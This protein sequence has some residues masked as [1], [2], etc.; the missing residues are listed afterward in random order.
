MRDTAGFIARI[1]AGEPAADFREDVPPAT[2]TAE[3]IAFGLR[4]DRG[5]AESLL[6]PWAETVAGH[7]GEGLMARTAGGR[8][9]LTPRGRMVADAV[10]EG[11]V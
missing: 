4:T 7:V 11:F 10:A 2:R 1:N 5:V 8:V 3:T 6:S 9:V